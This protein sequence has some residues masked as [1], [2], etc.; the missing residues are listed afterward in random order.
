MPNP[1]TPIRAIKICKYCFLVIALG[2]F[3]NV[4][5]RLKKLNDLLD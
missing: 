4:F 1:A 2:T 3:R 5:D